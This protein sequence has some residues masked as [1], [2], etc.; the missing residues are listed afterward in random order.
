[1]D[2]CKPLPHGPAKDTAS[3]LAR[4]GGVLG[5]RGATR[6]TEFH[7][8]SHHYTLTAD[9]TG[10]GDSIRHTAI[11]EGLLCDFGTA[12]GGACVFD[13]PLTSSDA[14]SASTEEQG[15]WSVSCSSGGC[16]VDC[17]GNCS[18]GGGGASSPPEDWDLSWSFSSLSRP[19]QP[20][21]SSIAR[22][23]R[24]GRGVLC[25]PECRQRIDR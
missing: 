20:T 14:D 11:M 12:R 8:S 3:L 18:S 2:E 6:V 1:V 9:L 15:A 23:R 5:P 21:I 25:T 17:G 19:Q 7:H 22:N 24:L 16:G 13:S 4:S 10:T